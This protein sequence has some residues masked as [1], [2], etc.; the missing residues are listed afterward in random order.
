MAGWSHGTAA[1]LI[2]ESVMI[3]VREAE[4]RDAEEWF[5]MREALWP[6]FREEHRDEIEA[7]LASPPPTEICL[8]A[9]LT[10]DRLVGFAELRLRQI[11][12]GCTTAPVGYLEGIWV[13]PE[14]RRAGVGQALLARGE[15]WARGKG[16]VEMASDRALDND[17]SGHFHGAAGFDEVIRAV[18]YRKDI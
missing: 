7:F 1:G 17:E 2:A 12:E 5:R 3:R 10:P 6:G 8:V 14:H 15:E 16:C 4:A 11:A 18:L 9:E 13:E